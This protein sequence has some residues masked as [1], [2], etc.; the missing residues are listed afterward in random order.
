LGILLGNPFSEGLFNFFGQFRREVQLFSGF[1]L[2][3]E[4]ERKGKEEKRAKTPLKRERS[5]KI[6]ES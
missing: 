1:L 5:S 3:K 4:G 6:G 2:K